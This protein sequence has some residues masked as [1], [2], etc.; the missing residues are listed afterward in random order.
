MATQANPFVTE[1][2]YLAH[3]RDSEQPS[4]YFG[5]EVFPI[6]DVSVRHVVIASKL[7]GVLI[8]ALEGSSCGVYSTGLRIGVSQTGLYTYPDLVVVCGKL[9]FAA[10]DRDT[11]TNPK[12]IVEIL[13]PST[14]DYDRGSKFDSYR[15]IPSFQEYLVVAQDRVFAQH[16]VKQPDGGWLLHDITSEVSTVSLES[17]GVRFHLSEAYAGVDL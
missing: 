10:K 16:W 17:I 9:E 8:R 3:E 15:T 5:G 1:E 6:E 11:V 14:Q 2:E 13:S 7:F 4:E 12:V